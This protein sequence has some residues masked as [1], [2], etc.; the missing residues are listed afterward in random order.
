[1]LSSPSTLL[2]FPEDFRPKRNE[3]WLMEP[4]PEVPRERNAVSCA[5]KGLEYGKP[6][7]QK[8]SLKCCKHTPYPSVFVPSLV[9]NQSLEFPPTTPATALWKLLSPEQPLLSPPINSRL[10]GQAKTRRPGSTFILFPSWGPW[11]GTNNQRGPLA[12]FHNFV[13]GIN[14]A[15]GRVLRERLREFQLASHCELAIWTLC[16]SPPVHCRRKP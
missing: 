14:P 7:P 4:I 13:Q 12:V 10:C 2:G 1:M 8:I 15:G 6:F 5:S 11:L 3:V 9:P 16:R